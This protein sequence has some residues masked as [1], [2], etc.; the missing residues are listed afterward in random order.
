MSLSHSDKILISCVS[1]VFLIMVWVAK[2]PDALGQ[3]LKTGFVTGGRALFLF[4]PVLTAVIL[5]IN[6]VVWMSR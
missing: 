1:T 2:P 6:L 5:I 4:R 3:K